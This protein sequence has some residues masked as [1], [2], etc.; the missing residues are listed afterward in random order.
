MAIPSDLSPEEQEWITKKYLYEH[1]VYTFR[2]IKEVI[3]KLNDYFDFGM[4]VPLYVVP[5]RRP[6]TG[7]GLGP[8]APNL[9]KR[10]RNRMVP[11]QPYVHIA[12]RGKHTK[13]FDGKGEWQVPLSKETLVDL[14]A[15][16]ASHSWTLSE[17]G[18]PMKLSM[19][20]LKPV[21]SR[22]WEDTVAKL[23]LREVNGIYEQA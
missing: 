16:E 17:R 7:I 2:I 20:F 15:H 11:E 12:P 9:W 13:D 19:E 5:K 6:S 8:L 23:N 18:D 3:K 1:D 14:L 22:L 10:D 4:T 21:I